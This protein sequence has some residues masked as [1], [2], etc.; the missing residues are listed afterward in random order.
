L[1]GSQRGVIVAALGFAIYFFGQWLLETW[2]FGSRGNFGWVA[3]APLS[4]SSIGQLRLLHPWVVLLF[5][6][7]LIAVW[8]CASLFILQPRHDDAS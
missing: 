4:A 2:E 8:L 3:Y 5:W 1:S 7:I 6:L